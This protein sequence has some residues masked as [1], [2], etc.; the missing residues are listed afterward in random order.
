MK[1]V[2]RFLFHLVLWAIGLYVMLVVIA[3]GL[4]AWSKGTFVEPLPAD[5]NE[6]IPSGRAGA[7]PEPVDT[8]PPS[9]PV[10]A[11]PAPS[12]LPDRAIRFMKRQPGGMGRM[13]EESNFR[14]YAILAE[15]VTRRSP[16]VDAETIL[17]ISFRESSWTTD[18]VGDAGEIGLMQLHYRNQRSILE[19]Y[20]VDAVKRSASLQLYLGMRRYE[21]ALD[22]C[23]GIPLEALLQYASGR[24]EGPVDP[25]DKERAVWSANR[26]LTWAERM[27]RDD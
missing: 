10:R 26:V 15:D 21:R 2:L 27:R 25:D 5:P 19:G 1:R 14:E 3:V 17:A 11:A 24:C 16:D 6:E 8:P 22:T 7:A 13:P 20:T 18:A 4:D 23:H 12:T 9:G